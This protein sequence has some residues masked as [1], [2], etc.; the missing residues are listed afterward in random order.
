MDIKS[1]NILYVRLNAAGQLWVKDEINSGE[2]DLASLRNRVK[3]F[4]KN[5]QNLSKLP[6]KHVK[7]IDLLGQCF[8]TDKHVVSVQTDRGTPYD[9]Y[10]QVQNE[11][12][13]AY[14][15]LRNELSKQKFGREYQYLKEEEKAAVRQYYPQN[16]S[17]AEPKKYGG[18]Q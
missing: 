4:V 5:E 12:V 8:V 16:I 1:R 15:E 2:Y 17:E 9:R 13:A 6:E 11:L 18:Q 7:N 14:N 3:E 10:F